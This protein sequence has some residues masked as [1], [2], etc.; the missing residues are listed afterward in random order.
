MLSFG[1]MG[2]L[3]GEAD[4]LQAR[5]AP[6]ETHEFWIRRHPG[7]IQVEE[8]KERSLRSVADVQPM[9]ESN[10]LVKPNLVYYGK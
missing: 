7:S 4:A 10:R 2:V 5:E 9:A 3:T 1:N 8:L 6:T